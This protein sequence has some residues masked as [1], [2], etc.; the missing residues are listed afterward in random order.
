MD[1]ED[2][3]MLREMARLDGMAVWARNHGEQFTA[4]EMEIFVLANMANI[5][6]LYMMSALGAASGDAV[7]PKDILDRTVA[8]LC[9]SF[10]KYSSLSMIDFIRISAAVLMSDRVSEFVIGL[11]TP[12]GSDAI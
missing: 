2:K 11:N 8:Y 12:E 9:D 3:E 5:G 1:D 6:M 4:S 7:K 10:P